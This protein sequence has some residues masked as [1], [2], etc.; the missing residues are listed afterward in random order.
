MQRYGD[1]PR[2]SASPC[3]TARAA[4]EHTHKHPLAPPLG[5]RYAC[6]HADTHTPL[7]LP[8]SP[9]IRSSGPTARR[10]STATSPTSSPS[11]R[12]W[13][14]RSPSTTTPSSVSWRGRCRGSS[15]FCSR[16]S[17]R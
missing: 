9:S 3:A 7:R 15:T 8:P 2:P 6:A 4:R 10:S 12:S 5:A 17:Q 13:R 14:R 11:R 16:L 1:G